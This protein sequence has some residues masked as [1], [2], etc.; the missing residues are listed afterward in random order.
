MAWAQSAMDRRVC[1]MLKVR[2][3]ELRSFA[4]LG[5]I[6]ATLWLFVTF[7]IVPLPS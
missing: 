6:S 2:R 7:A 4:V 1:K 5:A 3:S